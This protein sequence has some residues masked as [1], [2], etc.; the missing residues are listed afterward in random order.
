MLA[1]IAFVVFMEQAQRRI[2]VQY[3]KRV[4]G[5]RVY[6]GQNPYLPLKVNYSGV[7]PIIFAQAILMFPE[8]IFLFLGRSFGIK[9]FEEIARMLG[10]VTVTDQARAA[11]EALL[12]SAGVR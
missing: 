7:M 10:G 8:K 9:F 4:V 2:P 12:S 3:A 6:G 1:V 11:A 5:R